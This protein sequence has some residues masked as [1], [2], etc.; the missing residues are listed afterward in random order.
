MMMRRWLAVAV[1][2]VLIPGVMSVSSATAGAEGVASPRPARATTA[3]D[4][5]VR[6]WEW[7]PPDSNWADLMAG[8]SG[9]ATVGATHVTIDLT[10]LVDISEIPDPAKRT[11]ADEAFRQR[12]VDYTTAAAARGM[13]VSAVVGT[14]AWA[15]ANSRYLA[16]TVTGWVRRFNASQPRAQR[17]TALEVDVEPWVTPQWQSNAQR[18]LVIEWLRFIDQMRTEQ[19]A[20]PAA[21]QIPLRV[22]VPFW[23]DGSGTPASVRYGGKTMSATDHVLRL[24]DYRGASGNAVV[25]MAYRDTVTGA[26][27]SAALVAAEFAA[28]ARRGGRVAVVIG[29]DTAPTDTEPEWVT[30]AEEGRTQLLAAMDE[31]SGRFGHEAAFAGFSVNHAHHLATWL[32]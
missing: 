27:G 5:P 32:P 18:L 7:R 26:N 24:L 16:G 12:L 9:A 20:L 28:A 4:A 14:P 31:L 30:F 8:L 17:L 1:A 2:T 13:T 29:Q 19:R 25:V 6:V 22:D 10:R 3:A 15:A 11:G 23:F 21:E